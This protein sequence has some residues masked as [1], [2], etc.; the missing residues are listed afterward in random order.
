MRKTAKKASE[1]TTVQG[2]LDGRGLAAADGEIAA[3][4][5]VAAG[6]ALLELDVERGAAAPPTA[7]VGLL[8]LL[9]VGLLRVRHGLRSACEGE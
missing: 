5:G 2:A 7:G 3:D 6:A 9:L 8:D 4:P 1:K